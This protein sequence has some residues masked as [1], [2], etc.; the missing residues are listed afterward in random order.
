MRYDD[1]RRVFQRMG[2]DLPQPNHS[3]WIHLACPYAPWKHKGGVDRSQ[4]FS[5][6]VE[7]SGISAFSCPACKSKGR[8]EKLVRDLGQLRGHDYSA[9]EREVSQV[10]TMGAMMIPAWEDRHSRSFGMVETLGTPLDPVAFDPEAIFEDAAAIREARLY[11]VNRRITRQG[12]EKA[13]IRFDPDKRRLVFPVY[14]G[15]GHL[16]GFTGRT[17]LPKEQLTYM[18]ADGTPVTLPKVLDYANLPKRLLILGE[19]RWQ[20]GRGTVIVEGLFAYARFLSEDVDAHFNVGALLGSELTPGKAAILRKWGNPV[21]LILDPDDAGDAGIFGKVFEAGR[22]PQTGEP[23]MERD[24][25]TGA[26]Y[27]LADHVLTY[28]PQYPDGVL[29]PDDLTLEQVLTMCRAAM[30]VPK[31]QP[32]RRR[33][34]HPGGSRY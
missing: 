31:P 10:E 11:M 4:G 16:Y 33:R 20:K 6:K 32:P 12:M 3:G 13:G 28:V 30:P 26:L 29:D 18:R 14:D 27:Q 34:G 1:L 19:H 25:T 15:E 2:M 22:D 24:V 5:V 21:Y 9:L 8:I 7:D 23:I 17:I